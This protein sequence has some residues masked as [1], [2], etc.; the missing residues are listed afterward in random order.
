MLCFYKTPIILALLCFSVLAK[1]QNTCNVL[2]T[3]NKDSIKNWQSRL[4]QRNATETQFFKGEFAE[5]KKWLYQE[6]LKSVIEHFEKP[7]LITDPTA[8]NYIAAVM[9]KLEPA[10]KLFPTSDISIYLSRTGVP[11]AYTPGYKTVFINAGLFTRLQNEAQLAF[12]LCHELAHIFLKHSEQAV[13]NYLNS[14]FSKDFKDKVATIKKQEFGK[15]KAIEELFKNFSFDSRKHSRFKETAAD[16]LA[17]VWL[18]QTDYNLEQVMDCLQ[19]LDTI[20]TDVCETKLVFEKHLNAAEYPI[21]A[22]YFETPRR[23]IFG[24]SA[25]V[26]DIESIKVTDSL[27]THPDC[28]QRIIYSSTM[29]PDAMRKTGSKFL[30]DSLHFLH[31]QKR[32]KNELIDFALSNEKVSRGFFYAIEELNE[33]TQNPYV[34]ASISQA[35]NQLYE[36]QK[37]HILGKST[38]LPNP[39]MFT[40]S[41]N[42]LLYFIQNVS[43]ND[44]L[45]INYYYTTAALKIHPGCKDLANAMA[46]CAEKMG[47]TD[48]AAHWKKIF[49]QP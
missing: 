42:E 10:L 34:A 35:L 14:I 44:L 36:S 49:D 30:V 39:Q 47:K 7:E 33:D 13:D 20:D 23:S 21:K 25:Y 6:K 32:L 12:V 48:E 1:G 8:N 5:H 26:G 40:R 38:D 31:L 43:L 24:T 4:Q 3:Q 9:A 11:N 15:G 19:L 17:I 16:S 27:R 2:F 37:N 29:I 41:Y 28:K 22:N 45:K 46:I 18:R